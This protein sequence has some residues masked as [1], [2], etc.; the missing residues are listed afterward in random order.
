MQFFFQQQLIWL[1]S[2]FKLLGGT[3]QFHSLSRRW[4]S[5]SPLFVKSGVSQRVRQS[6][7]RIWSSPFLSP[8]I[9]LLSCGCG[10]LN[11]LVLEGHKIESFFLRFCHPVSYRLKPALREKEEITHPKLFPF[12]KC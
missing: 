1:D 2:H 12:P 8:R 7:H 10:C 4:A 3:S 9:S 5:Q 6:L 11:L